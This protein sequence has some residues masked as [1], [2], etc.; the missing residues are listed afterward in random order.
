MMCE[1]CWHDATTEVMIYGGCLA[2][3]YMELLN[4]RKYRPCSPRDQKR[5]GSRILVHEQQKYGHESFR[6]E[7]K[8]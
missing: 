3:R 5:C 1:K 2:D 6:E 7:N 8:K 4:E